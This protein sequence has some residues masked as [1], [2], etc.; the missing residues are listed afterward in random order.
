MHCE[1]KAAVWT[2]QKQGALSVFIEVIE[3]TSLLPKLRMRKG[4]PE[5]KKGKKGTGN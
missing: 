2:S 1:N 4:C 3:S 5:R